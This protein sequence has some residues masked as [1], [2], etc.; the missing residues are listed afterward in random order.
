[1]N[2]KNENA[3]NLVAKLIDNKTWWNIF[4]HYKHRLVYEIRVESGHG[5]RWNK[6][7]TNIIGFLEPFINK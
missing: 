6:E 7:E 2:Q 1:M 5:I 4:F 3:K